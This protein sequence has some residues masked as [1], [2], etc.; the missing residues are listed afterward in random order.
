MKEEWLPTFHLGMLGCAERGGS[1]NPRL[2]GLWDVV[3][4]GRA[5]PGR[6]LP[7]HTNCFFTV[8]RLLQNVRMTAQTLMFI[9]RMMQA[10][11]SIGVLPS[12]RHST[13]SDTY[14]LPRPHHNTG[15]RI[16]VIQYL[17]KVWRPEGVLGQTSVILGRM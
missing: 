12:S 15:N 6:F 7:C 17:P 3:V 4:R 11:P 2:L 13:R 10:F 5:G 16:K 14:L 1:G 9:T 8:P